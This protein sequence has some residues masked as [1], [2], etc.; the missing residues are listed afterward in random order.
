MSNLA[1]IAIGLIV[2]GLLLVRQLQPRPVRE[3]S[4]IRLV[5]ILG[6][7]GIFE[8]S[9]AVGHHHL[10]AAAVAWLAVSLMA[11]AVTGA[12][13]AA[14]VRV[15]RAQDGSAWRQGTVLT[16][17]LWVISLGA[18]LA[19]DTVID[20]AS[21]IAALGTSS[22]LLYLAVTLGIQR[23]IVHRRAAPLAPAEGEAPARSLFTHAGSGPA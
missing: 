21:R 18:H 1:N 10:T 15:W 9:N 19:L 3:A 4:S 16:A 17:A 14:T 7:A 2:V 12:I 5:L 22:I 6:A 23:E 11:G 8:T 20:H 13:R